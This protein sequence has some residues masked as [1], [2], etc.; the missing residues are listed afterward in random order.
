MQ[1]VEAIRERIGYRWPTILQIA[2]KGKKTWK[3]YRSVGVDVVHPNNEVW[4]KELFA[5][6]CPGKDKFFGRQE[7]IRWVLEAVAVFGEGDVTPN[8]V[9]GVEMAQPYGFN[10]VDSAVRST[11]EGIEFLM[12]HGVIP[13][14]DHWNISPLS[15]LAGNHPPSLKF[16]IRINQVLRETWVKHD[17]PPIHSLGPV[18]PGRARHVVSGLLDMAA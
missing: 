8:F 3:R 10:D 4:D 16:F 14:L 17:L 2:A 13:R 9:N 7:W 5:W 15:V 18:G 12:P 6:F 11:T 1:Y